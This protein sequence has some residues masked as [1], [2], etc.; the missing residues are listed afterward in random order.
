MVVDAIDEL[1]VQSVLAAAEGRWLL[2]PVDT[3]LLGL[4]V[5]YALGG[6][7]VSDD[8]FLDRVRVVWSQQLVEL[9]CELCAAPAA[10]GP[11]EA[12]FLFPR[13]LPGTKVLARF[14]R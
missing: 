12:R 13:G 2:A 9:V 10:L 5:A 8:E 11:E 14:C 1:N 3:P 7:G 6:F 4:D